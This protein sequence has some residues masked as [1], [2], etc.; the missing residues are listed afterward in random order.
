MCVCVC[1]WCVSSVC[2]CECGVCAV[3]SAIVVKQHTSV[4]IRM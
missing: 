3:G 2:V 4:Y 1:V